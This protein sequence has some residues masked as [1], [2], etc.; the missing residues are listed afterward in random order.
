MSLINERG[1]QEWR[2][3][4]LEEVATH[5]PPALTPEVIKDAEEVYERVRH[6]IS[7]N[8][9]GDLCSLYI[10]HSETQKRTQCRIL[11]HN[12]QTPEIFHGYPT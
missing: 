10:R 4:V 7:P 2:Q 3:I 5:R 6:V 1:G 9:M 12:Y 8:G 11:A